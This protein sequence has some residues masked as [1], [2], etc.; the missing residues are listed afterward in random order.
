MVLVVIV[1]VLYLYYVYL[2]LLTYEKDSQSTTLES[3]VSD[4]GLYHRDGWMDT[5]KQF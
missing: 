5:S 3:F 2:S 4:W 1:E